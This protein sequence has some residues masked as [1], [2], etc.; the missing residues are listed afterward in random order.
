MDAIGA[1]LAA[2]S[3]FTPPYYHWKIAEGHN[4]VA[5]AIF[6]G[7]A[8]VV[9]RFVDAATRRAAEA[10]RARSQARTSASLAAT[11]G[12]QDPL[13]TLLR[14][15]RSVFRLE[16]CGPARCPSPPR[17]RPPAARPTRGGSWKRA[18]GSRSPLFPRTPT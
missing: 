3:Y 2:N 16:G 6:L 18:E 8:L 12:E 15:M 14:H 5:L 1:F 11:M 9:S 13:P 7:V 4:V 17:L 10:S